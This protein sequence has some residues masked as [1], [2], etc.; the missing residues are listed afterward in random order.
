MYAWERQ[1]EELN[2]DSKEKKTVKWVNF[3]F[4][5]KCDCFS[6]FSELVC[7][8]T[9]SSEVVECCEILIKC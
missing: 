8:K 7:T 1:R 3:R 2:N 6:Y 5:E 4:V 9:S